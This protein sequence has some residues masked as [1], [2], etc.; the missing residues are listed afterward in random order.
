MNRREIG[1]SKEDVFSLFMKLPYVYSV[2]ATISQG[3]VKHYNICVKTAVMDIASEL[4]SI[5][6]YCVVSGENSELV[7]DY[8]VKPD[9]VK[10]FINRLSKAQCLS[11]CVKQNCIALIFHLKRPVTEELKQTISRAIRSTDRVVWGDM[12]MAVVLPVSSPEAVKAVEERIK[13]LLKRY[14]G[15][16]EISVVQQV[17]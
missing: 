12:R 4:M 8:L 3:A 1:G 6:P 7:A 13:N 17:V 11:R 9:E 16:E 15:M 2:H 14:G 10:L 5:W